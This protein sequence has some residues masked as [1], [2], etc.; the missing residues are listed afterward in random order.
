[1]AAVNKKEAR[2]RRKKRVRK[3]VKGV[4]EVPRLSVFKSSKHIYAQVIDDMTSNTL[5]DASSLSKDLRPQ[6]HGKG[7]NREGAAFIGEWIAKRALEKGINQVVFDRN[8]FLY[9]G[10]VK[11]LAESARQ[12]GLK[13]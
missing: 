13:F 11:V 2:L 9:H 10:R 7:G 5:V 6:V 8:G 1:M 12:H 3:R 4:P